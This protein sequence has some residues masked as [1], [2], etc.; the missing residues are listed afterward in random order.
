MAHSR[1][2]KLT[3]RRVGLQSGDDTRL[4]NFVRT[5]VVHVDGGEK[6]DIALFRHSRRHGLHDLAIDR[7]FVVGHEILIEELLDLVR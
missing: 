2:E 7:L 6:Q 4:G 3:R 5:T 1:D